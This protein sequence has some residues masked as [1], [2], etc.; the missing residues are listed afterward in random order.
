MEF[1]AHRGSLIHVL[2]ANSNKPAAGCR[3][4]FDDQKARFAA[5]TCNCDIMCI[6]V[7]TVTPFVDTSV[8]QIHRWKAD[9]RNEPAAAIHVQCPY[10]EG[11]SWSDFPA[12]RRRTAVSLRKTRAVGGSSHMAAITVRGRAHRKP[13]PH[14][15]YTGSWR[16]GR[17]SFTGLMSNKVDTK[18]A[19]NILLITACARM[20]EKHGVFTGSSN[21]YWTNT[22]KCS[23]QLAV[24]R[25][26]PSAI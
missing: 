2:A 6:I 24:N 9:D 26:E 11:A 23:S 18:W 1:L 13:G 16:S 5:I 19:D 4:G 20:A 17:R 8:H 25:P 10:I 22:E 3:D 12:Q 15:R 7:S 14:H 21:T